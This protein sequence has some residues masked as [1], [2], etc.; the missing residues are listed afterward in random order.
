MAS[1][2]SFDRQWVIP[3]NRLMERARTALWAVRSSRQIFVSE[4]IEPL[5]NGPGLVFCSFVPDIHHFHGS[6]GSAV[7]PLYRD[8][9]G[10]SVN[11][12][13][14]LLR[15]LSDRTGLTISAEDFLAYVAA[16]VAH[17][18]YTETIFALPDGTWGSRPPHHRGEPVESVRA[19]RAGGHLA[20][21][22]RRALLR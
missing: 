14:R 3:D 18:G 12:T 6:E 11:V 8:A 9:A 7:R 10:M 2:R 17:R 22:L 19:D 21:H 16:L 15:Y 13:P 1:Y 20:A 5:R 4:D